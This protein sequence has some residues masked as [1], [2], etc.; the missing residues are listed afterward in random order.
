MKKSRIF[1]ATGALAL[2][3]SAVFATKARK[4]FASVTT[5]IS[6]NFTVREI[7][8]FDFMTTQGSNINNSS[9]FVRLVTV[10]GAHA[11]LESDA[12]VTKTSTDHPVWFY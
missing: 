6:G 7:A 3:I 10:I 4:K 8:G 2:A 9:L 12:L 11:I 1:M 5:A